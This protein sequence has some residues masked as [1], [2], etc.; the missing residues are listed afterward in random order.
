MEGHYVPNAGFFEDVVYGDPASSS[1]SQGPDSVEDFG[2]VHSGQ[3]YGYAVGGDVEVNDVKLEQDPGASNQSDMKNETAEQIT[4]DMSGL[5]VTDNVSAEESN[6]EKN[7]QA[8]SSEEVD[9]LLDKCLL[10]ALHTTVK[11]KDLPVPGSTLW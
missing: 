4:L 6:A 3:T 5:R 8:L 9:A 11:D 10:Q 1:G 2:D 7:Q